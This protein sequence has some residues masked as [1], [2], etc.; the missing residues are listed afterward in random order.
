VR[1]AAAKA[2]DLDPA[3]VAPK[4]ALMAIAAARPS[5]LEEI[6]ALDVLYRWQVDLLGPDLLKAL[7]PPVPV[8]GRRRRRRRR[9]RRAAT[10]PASTT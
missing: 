6:R 8:P 4:A 2:L 3:L 7:A 5:T 9:R 10:A 1:D